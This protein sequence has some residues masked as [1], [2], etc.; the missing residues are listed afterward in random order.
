MR[1]LLDLDKTQLRRIDMA[2][3]AIDQPPIAEQLKKIHLRLALEGERREIAKCNPALRRAP[4]F[5]A[6]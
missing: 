2:I 3:A 6:A 5:K 4:C 1:S